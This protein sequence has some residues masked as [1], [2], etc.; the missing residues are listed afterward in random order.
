M[1]T[2]LLQCSSLICVSSV[3]I[4]WAMSTFAHF[5]NERL[6]REDEE[7]QVYHQLS[8]LTV[9]F[10]LPIFIVSAILSAF[11][12]ALFFAALMVVFTLA[13][14]FVR[15]SFLFK[16]LKEISLKVGGFFLKINTWLLKRILPM[17][18]PAT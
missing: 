16:R 8:W 7:K 3:L 13:L 2:A 4:V 18:V 1:R 15:E 12:Y 5:Y 6:P 10:T 17:P 9:P 11:F 14:L